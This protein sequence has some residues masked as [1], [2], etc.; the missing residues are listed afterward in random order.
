MR[1]RSR[2]VRAR[3]LPVRLPVPRRGPFRTQAGFGMISAVVATAAL[4]LLL[5]TIAIRMLH[6]M[7]VRQGEMMGHDMARLNATVVDF[8]RRYPEQIKSAS[9]GTPSPRQPAAEQEKIARRL[10]DRLMKSRK[11]LPQNHFRLTLRED[12]DLRDMVRSISAA[13]V[14]IR[15]P[16]PERRYVIHIDV[17]GEHCGSRQTGACAVDSA[18]YIDKPIIRSAGV[19]D[20]LK[21]ATAL[22]QLGPGGGMSLPGTPHRITFSPTPRTEEVLPYENPAKNQPAGILLIDNLR[23][24]DHLPFLRVTGG[25]IS[26]PVDM[27]HHDLENIDT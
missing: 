2:P 16:L 9:T 14:H 15:P 19:I 20:H 8:T 1:D 11:T 3:A 17:H 25:Q 27:T 10:L 26:G 12:E 18:L 23:R 7:R 24:V 4:S 6:D 5:G 22:R 21:L 13:G